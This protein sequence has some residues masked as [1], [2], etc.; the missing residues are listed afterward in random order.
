LAAF[1]AELTFAIAVSPGIAS[2][3]KAMAGEPQH[4]G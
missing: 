3:D 1:A 4:E 2:K